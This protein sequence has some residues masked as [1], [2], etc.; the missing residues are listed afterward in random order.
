MEVKEQGSDGEKE[1]NFLNIGIQDLN[2]GLKYKKY[3]V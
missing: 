2:I 1:I 3:L